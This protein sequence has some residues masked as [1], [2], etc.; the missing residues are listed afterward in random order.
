MSSIRRILAIDGG[1]IKGAMPAAFLAQIEEVTGERVVD[2]FDLIAGTSTGGIIALGLA[3]GLPAREI[4]EF[5]KSHGPAIFAQQQENRFARF[6]AKCGRGL[7]WFCAGPKYSAEPLRR[8]LTDAVGTRRIGE[9]STRVIIP[10]YQ[11]DRRAVY[12]FKTAHHPRFEFDYKIKAVDVLM[13]TAAAPTFL[14]THETDHGIRLI[15]GGIWAN[16][17]AGMAAVEAIGVLGWDPGSTRMLS[18]GC[19]QQV[20]VPK[21]DRGAIRLAFDMVD[22]FMQGQSVSST[23]TAKI[24]LTPDNFHRI[25]PPFPKNF[26]TLDGV[27][28][29][30]ELAGIGASCAREELPMIRK[31]FL[32]DKREAFEPCRRLN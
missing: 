30:S 5:Y 31:E 25:D 23:G 12:V 10:A 7:R 3:L 26:F 19:C 32:F 22:L 27:A 6:A 21:S 1:G 24:L 15:D 8:A 4:L 28:K 14:P 11:A 9:C 13:A 17:P 18:L 16:N 29:I 2:H 20:A